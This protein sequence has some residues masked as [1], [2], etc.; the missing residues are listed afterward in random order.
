M[1]LLISDSYA[2][3]LDG[4]PLDMKNDEHM[5]EARRL[6]VASGIMPGNPAVTVVRKEN[7]SRATVYV[8]DRR[9]AEGTAMGADWLR[10]VLIA[11]GFKAAVETVSSDF[12]GLD[13]PD[14]LAEYRKMVAE[15]EIGALKARRAALA[16][17]LADI[18]REIEV[19]KAAFGSPPA[20]PLQIK[21]PSPP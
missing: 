13:L 14:S 16:G 9:V 4:R 2:P 8:G 5:K 1:N 17:E 20:P 6:I 3:C 19:K 15:L 21:L 12:A 18:D 11:M 10:N 7:P